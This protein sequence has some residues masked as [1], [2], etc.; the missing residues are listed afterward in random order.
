[1]SLPPLPK[2]HHPLLPLGKVLIVMRSGHMLTPAE[3][4]DK[5][6]GSQIWVIMNNQKGM[7]VLSTYKS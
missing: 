1:M 4:V 5:C 7:C 2:V 6:V 3:L